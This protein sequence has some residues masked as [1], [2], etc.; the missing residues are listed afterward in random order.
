MGFATFYYLRYGIEWDKWEHFSPIKN[1][2][3]AQYLI[4]TDTCLVRFTYYVINQNEH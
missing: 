1:S 2:S 3:C 4:K